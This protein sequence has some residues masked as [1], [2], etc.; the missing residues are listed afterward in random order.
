MHPHSLHFDK[1]ILFIS[2][3]LF[4][5]LVLA[6]VGEYPFPGPPAVFR[7]NTVVAGEI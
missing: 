2:V 6:L 1:S 5:A 4:L 7:G 3:I